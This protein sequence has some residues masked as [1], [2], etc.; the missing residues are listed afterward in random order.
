MTTYLGR[1][2]I[3]KHEKQWS[4][5]YRHIA[6]LACMTKAYIDGKKR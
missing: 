3:F 5:Q 4:Q 6:T 1:N 2:E